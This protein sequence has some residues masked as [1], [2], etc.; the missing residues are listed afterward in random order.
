MP[1]TRRPREVYRLLTEEQYLAGEACSGQLD[2]EHAPP[3][4]SW[5]LRTMLVISCVGIGCSAAVTAVT[6]V[7]VLLAP[8]APEKA[9]RRTPIAFAGRPP[10]PRRRPV[11]R[12][13]TPA[14]R[15]A[16]LGSREEVSGEHPAK[17]AARDV[18]PAKTATRAIAAAAPVSA[19]PVSE[20]GM[21]GPRV[22]SSASVEFGFER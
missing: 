21:P 8:A 19:K 15:T 17:P 20:T 7:L 9:A 11:P 6:A 14:Q 5:R 3:A 18:R 10:R 16:L 12:P 4:R 1:L 22:A 2:G 13:G